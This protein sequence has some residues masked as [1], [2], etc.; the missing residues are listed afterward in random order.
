ME[1]PTFAPLSSPTL[2]ESWVRAIAAEDVA[3]FGLNPGGT[4]SFGIDSDGRIHAPTIELE[5]LQLPTVFDKEGIWSP[6]ALIAEVDEEAD[7][8]AI[9]V[10]AQDTESLQLKNFYLEPAVT[11]SD[12]P[13]WTANLPDVARIELIGTEEARQF[14]IGIKTTDGNAPKVEL[15]VPQTAAE[16][17]SPKKKVAKL[18]GAAAAALAMISPFAIDTHYDSA[19]PITSADQMVQPAGTLWQDGI[20]QA[21]QEFKEPELTRSRNAFSAYFAGDTA[22]LQRQIEQYGFASNWINP[23][24]ITKLQSAQT[25]AELTTAFDQAMEGLPITLQPAT[26]NAALEKLSVREKAYSTEKVS[27]VSEIKDVAA[28]IFDALNQFDRRFLQSLETPL[29][30]VPV[31]DISAVSNAP[32]ANAYHN[33]AENGAL[34]VINAGQSKERN[35]QTAA[36]ELGHYLD[37]LFFM[38][39]KVDDLN[40]NSFTYTQRGW[41]SYFRP[42]G[43]AIGGNW[44]TLNK[45]ADSNMLEDAAESTA[46]LVDPNKQIILNAST[47]NEKISSVLFKLE[48]EM[49][50]FTAAFLARHGVREAEPELTYVKNALPYA[51]AVLGMGWMLTDIHR[52]RKRRTL[53]NVTN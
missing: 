38:R 47:A 2:H 4:F 13:H 21:E 23:A 11:S 37:E 30:F 51:P 32:S 46:L 34:I 24:A 18:L 50:G 49:P 29:A 39:F 43:T 22:G 14:T 25:V 17:P 45:N 10:I 35:T 52:G 1:H 15:L 6:L 3:L 5:Q 40:P 44:I 48:K 41:A 16:K 36:H 33:Y 7:T 27:D 53:A 31:G 12:E 8:R 26:D 20:K 9:R 19:S 42:F 28:G